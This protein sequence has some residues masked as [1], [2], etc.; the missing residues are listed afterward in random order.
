MTLH[1]LKALALQRQTDISGA[2][3]WLFEQ[4]PEVRASIDRFMAGK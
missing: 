3:E 1:R 4:L 2:I